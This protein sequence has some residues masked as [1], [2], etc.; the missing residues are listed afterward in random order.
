[1]A[2]I[3]IPYASSALPAGRDLSELYVWRSDNAAGPYQKLGVVES[4]ENTVAGRTDHLS[5]FV[6]AVAEL[7]ESD[8]G[9]YVS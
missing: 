7:V 6:A 4:D 8:G 3:S 1:M 2:T 5:F 9:L